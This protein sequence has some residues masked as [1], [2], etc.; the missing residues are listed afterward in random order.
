LI[1]VHTLFVIVLVIFGFLMLIGFAA[2]SD[3]PPPQKTP[4]QQE[5]EQLRKNR[6]YVD[7]LGGLIEGAYPTR[8]NAQIAYGQL[9]AFALIGSLIWF[10]VEWGSVW[11]TKILA[12]I[13]ALAVCGFMAAAQ[14]KL[15]YWREWELEKDGTLAQIFKRLEAALS[16]E[17]QIILLVLGALA[18]RAMG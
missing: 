5:R 18:G 7:Q 1:D 12:G 13:L 15:K 2:V 9:T 17:V 11:W 14:K 16:W 8:T 3:Q 4:E 10:A 6:E